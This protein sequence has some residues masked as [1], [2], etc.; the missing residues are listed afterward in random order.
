[1]Q[2]PSRSLLGRLGDVAIPIGVGVVLVLIAIDEY[3]T[4]T[5]WSLLLLRL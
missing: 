1:V 2:L 3:A 5:W 4:P